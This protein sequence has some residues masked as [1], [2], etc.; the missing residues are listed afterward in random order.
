MD[1]MPIF[2]V[3]KGVM[4]LVNTDLVDEYPEIQI[5]H[6]AVI[7]Y[8]IYARFSALDCSVGSVVDQVCC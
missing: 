2:S 3:F 4:V 5:E 6:S 8:S 1:L 7:W